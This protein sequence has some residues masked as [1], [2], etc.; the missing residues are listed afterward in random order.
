MTTGGRKPLVGLRP[1]W[2]ARY[3]PLDTSSVRALQ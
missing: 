2:A 1:L 3:L